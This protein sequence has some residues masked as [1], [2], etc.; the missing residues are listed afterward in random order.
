MI[1]LLYRSPL[2][3]P[4][5]A[6][7]KE[8]EPND[9]KKCRLEIHAE[10]NRWEKEGPRDEQ[11][12]IAVR[13]IK[14]S[15]DR[16]TSYLDLSGL[17]LRSLPILPL[18]LRMIVLDNNRLTS[19]I[20]LPANLEK[21]LMANNLLESLPAF[22]ISMRHLD[23]R[24]NLLA[25]ISDLSYAEQLE[26]LLIGDNKLESMPTVPESIRHLDASGNAGIAIP[27]M[28]YA[29]QLETLVLR[30]NKLDSWPAIPASIRHIDVYDNEFISIPD[31]SYAHLETLVIGKNALESLPMIPV[32]TQ[33]L[34]AGDNLLAAIPD[35]SYAKNLQDIDLSD[36]ALTEIPGSLLHVRKINLQ[37]NC[38]SEVEERIREMPLGNR[39]NLKQNP[40]SEASRLF[41]RRYVKRL[42]KLPEYRKSLAEWRPAGTNSMLDQHRA[43]NGEMTPGWD[44]IIMDIDSKVKVFFGFLSR[45]RKTS[46]AES[47]GFRDRIWTLLERIAASPNLRKAAFDAAWDATESCSDRILQTLTKMEMACLGDDVREGR[48]DGRIPE[49]IEAARKVFRN[50]CL[51]EIAVQKINALVAE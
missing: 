40:L 50:E 20:V 30:R 43:E 4:S 16:E 49:L 44:R 15:F 48:Y 32:S 12:D 8:S 38:I 37:T 25:S 29:R 7:L 14:D 36:N 11:R 3:R 28:S 46:N 35:L 10:L 42:A 13:R 6:E 21:L 24:G 33:H 1:D 41:L 26:T 45:L 9:G 51:D 34:D 18:S 22:G 17:G 23:V 39:I 19:D 31:L 5:T 2:L 47:R 27:D